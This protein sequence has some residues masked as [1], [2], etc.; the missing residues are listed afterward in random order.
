MPHY[1]Y[2]IDPF[3]KTITEVEYSGDYKQIYDLI[4]CECFDVARINGKG[5]GIFVDDEGLIREKPQAFFIHANYP[6]PLAGKGFLLGSNDEGD[7]VTPYC[8]L[9]ELEQSILWV[10]PLRMPNGDIAWRATA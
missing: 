2:L 4:D 5:D 3:A 8:T 1:G 6:T 9:A 7:S 10:E